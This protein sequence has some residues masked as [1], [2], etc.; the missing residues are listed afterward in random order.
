MSEHRA[1]I[2]RSKLGSREAGGVI[3][4]ARAGERAVGALV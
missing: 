3:T 4:S 1:G 2:G